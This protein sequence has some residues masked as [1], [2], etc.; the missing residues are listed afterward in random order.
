MLKNSNNLDL[1]QDLLLQQRYYALTLLDQANSGLDNKAIMLL[2][3]A[4]LIFA[5]IGALQFPKFIYN[6][7][8]WIILAIGAAFLSFAIMVWLLV[9][10][11]LPKVSYVPGTDDWDKLHA[12]Y[13]NVEDGEGFTQIL[14]DCTEAYKRLMIINDEKAT[15]IK[16]AGWLFILQI[17]GLLSVSVLSPLQ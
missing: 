12:E 6:T 16:W 13:L 9:S 8:F 1:K 2:Q 17:A 14:A 7:T 5:L 3:A 4:S 10:T 11:W 15:K